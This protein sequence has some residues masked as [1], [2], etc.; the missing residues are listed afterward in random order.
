MGTL[1]EEVAIE[2]SEEDM[3]RYGVSFAEIAQAIANSSINTSAG[4]VR[5][6]LGDVRIA[7]RELADT[8]YEFENIIVRQ[9]SDGGV[10]RVGDVATVIDGL[11]DANLN[12]TF[13]GEQMVIIAI[14]STGS[15]DIIDVSN[16]MKEYLERKNAELPSTLQ[17]SV[18]WDGA[19]QFNSQLTVIGSSAL[20]GLE[21]QNLYQEELHEKSG[22]K[23]IRR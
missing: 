16:A 20:L 13:D 10:V 1:G 5:T 21:K 17:L 19:D 22:D 8:A 4:S 2:V 11:V 18:W 7:S 3:R 9:T 23:L 12:A 15:S 14:R 6:D